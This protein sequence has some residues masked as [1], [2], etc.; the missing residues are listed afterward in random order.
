[1]AL[2]AVKATYWC[3]WLS[4]CLFT[5]PH[6]CLTE[7]KHKTEIIEQC[8]HLDVRNVM[9]VGYCTADSE[10]KMILMNLYKLFNCLRI[11]V[12]ISLSNLSSKA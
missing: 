10:S 7:R 4:W 8:T 1:M 5:L 3:Q 2:L 12:F 6:L 11:I 9:P